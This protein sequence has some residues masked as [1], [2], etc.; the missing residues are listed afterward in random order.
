[1]TM[2]EMV[3]ETIFECIERLNRERPEDDRVPASLETLL[4]FEGG[5]LDSLEL[6]SL[7][8]DLEEA[9]SERFSCAITLTDDEAMS[10]E[11]SP[12]AS[13]RSLLDY[14]LEVLSK[15]GK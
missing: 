6:V 13:V 1:M 11:D 4:L 2:R 10:R 12:F 3:K 9:L 7:V 14:A 5:A 15:N 8:V